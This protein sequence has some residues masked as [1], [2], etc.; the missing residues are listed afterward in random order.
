MPGVAEVAGVAGVAAGVAAGVVGVAGVSGA[1]GRVAAYAGPQ[2][3]VPAA[4]DSA[5]AVAVD[6][7]LMAADCCCC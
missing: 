6:A 4:V 7:E 5:S 3:I 2:A 1:V